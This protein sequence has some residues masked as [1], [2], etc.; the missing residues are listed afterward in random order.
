LVVPAELPP[1][2]AFKQQQYRWAK[3]ASKPPRKLIPALLDFH[4]AAFPKI[5]GSLAPDGLLGQLL[6]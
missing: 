1:S 6:W 5:D 2:A 3:V 4:A